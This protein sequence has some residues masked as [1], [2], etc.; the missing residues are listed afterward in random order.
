MEVVVVDDESLLKTG[1]GNAGAAAEI[2]VGAEIT[3]D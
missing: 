1:S 2:P 3:D